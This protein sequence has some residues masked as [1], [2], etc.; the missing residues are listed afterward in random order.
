MWRGI[1]IGRGCRLKPDSVR[2]RIPFALPIQVN[3]LTAKYMAPTHT[4]ECSN[5]SWPARRGF[6]LL[7]QNNFSNVYE[8]AITLDLFI[9][10]YA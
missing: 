8:V 1:P 4:D 9:L 10:S 5:H 2:V 3:S 7:L 6:D